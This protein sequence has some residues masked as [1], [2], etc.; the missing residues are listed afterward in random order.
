MNQEPVQE[1]KF[2]MTGNVGPVGP[3]GR[4]GPTGPT[5]Q[6]LT[7]VPLLII[8]IAIFTIL[9]ITLIAAGYQ[10]DNKTSEGKWFYWMGATCCAY[11]I[12]DLIILGIKNGRRD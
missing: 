2:V 1:T 12:Y 8:G 11:T 5:E 6:G 4:E 10:A 3:T 7:N 9:T